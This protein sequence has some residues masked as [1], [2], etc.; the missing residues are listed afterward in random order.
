M[1]LQYWLAEET[2]GSDRYWGIANMIVTVLRKRCEAS[3]S[4]WNA[5]NKDKEKVALTLHFFDTI[6][7][8]LDRSQIHHRCR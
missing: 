6:F 8:F 4:S 1:S 5:C 3:T 7:I 2:S